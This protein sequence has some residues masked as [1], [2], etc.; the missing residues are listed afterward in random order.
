MSVT[1]TQDTLGRVSQPKNSIW[2]S[3]N[4]GSGKTR[5]LITRVAR[6]LLQ[7][8][9]PE[10]ILC[11]TYTTAAASE[12]QD[13]LF[14]ELGS[15]SM[16]SD[17]DLKEILLA[18]DGNIFKKNKKQSKILSTARRLFAKALETP[19]GL[20]I[21]TI[22]SF[23]GTVLRK[24]PLEINLSPYFTILDERRKR[25]IIEQVITK[26]L[27]E[28]IEIFDSVIQLLKVSDINY[29]IDQILINRTKLDVPFDLDAFCKC[30]N[31]S[32]RSLSSSKELQKIFSVRPDN[33]IALLINSLSN[34]SSAD[35]RQVQYLIKIK[36]CINDTE[37]LNLL[38]QF[39][40]TE[41]GKIRSERSFPSKKAKLLEP[42]LEKVYLELKAGFEIY[43]SRRNE[44]NAI[45][46]AK[47]FYDFSYKFFKIYEKIKSE[48]G[49]LDYD[50]LIIKT[51]D[52]L[53]NYQSKWVLYKLDGGI[54]HILLD[55]AQDTSI[56][57]WEMLAALMED[58]FVDERS[59]S[60]ERTF[61]AVGDEKQ[62]I[63]SFQGA[64][65][66]SFSYMKEFF[67]KKLSVLGNRLESVELLDSFRSSSAIL[68]FVN[69]ILVDSGG[70]GV[71]NINQHRAFHE[72]LPGRVELWPLVSEKRQTNVY[73]WWN[74]KNEIAEVSGIDKLA[75][76]IAIEIKKVLGSDQTLFEPNS[77][78]A[79]K[80]RK[81]SPGDFLILV[82]SRGPLF[83]S[84]LKKLTAHN[85]P[86]AGSDRLLLL[87]ELVIKDLVSLLKF[88][89]NSSDDLSLAEVLRSP[90]LGFSEEDLFKVSYGR[91]ATLYEAL[92]LKFP[93][94]EAVTILN[95]LCER[96]K[97][98]A[99]YELIE[100]VLI[101]HGGRLKMTARL[102]L[103]VNEIL[104][105]FLVQVLNY[106][107][108]EPPS[109]YGFLRW[110]SGIEVAVKRQLHN[111][112]SSIRVMTV[113]GSKGLESPIVIIPDT[114]KNFQK[115]N[116][117]LFLQKDGWL[118]LSD[119][120][121]NLPKEFKKI[122]E[123]YLLDEIEEENR[124]FYVAVTRA[125]NWLIINGV[126]KDKDC[127]KTSSWYSRSKT[128]LKGLESKKK[129]SVKLLEGG[130]L[131]YDYSWTS[132]KTI[133]N[134]SKQDNNDSAILEDTNKFKRTKKVLFEKVRINSRRQKQLTVSEIVNLVTDPKSQ[135]LMKK[136][137][138]SSSIDEATLYGSLVH[139]FLQY[140]PIFMDK[141]SGYLT[142]MIR[143]KFR[144]QLHDIDM[145]SRA[146]NQS[147]SIFEKPELSYLFSNKNILREV[148]VTGLVCLNNKN[149]NS[150]KEEWI[151]GRIDLL[152]IT[153]T[154][155]HIVDFKTN[156]KVPE[157]V[158][159]VS[160]L[161]LS[162][163]ELYT[164]ILEQAY[165]GRQVSSAILWTQKV[166]LMKIPRDKSQN[167]LNSIYINQ[168]LDE[169]LAQF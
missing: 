115:N 122:K 74:F 6:I 14:K 11:L 58:F 10:K 165:P 71:K 102:G 140:L 132:G 126:D 70:T 91:T 55:E 28:N 52:L 45:G 36:Y 99:P 141:S 47:V 34:G 100:T 153:E 16:K 106:E 25:V 101:N 149:N 156:F 131:V 49:V 146:Y 1:E 2:V 12:M 42:S 118:C 163:L 17:V 43:L 8:A 160:P 105:E 88:L 39:F 15:W 30:F 167:A 59:L 107:E 84:I 130:K 29:F 35:I 92:I 87:D 166:E 164:L 82:R 37:K 108:E 67:S 19:G 89:I 134:F 145:V 147:L 13:R 114:S 18:L 46:K 83:H 124:L 158:D 4:A 104:D 31:L 143:Y 75:E 144:N 116:R 123:Q 69:E 121:N 125:K 112:S 162:Q 56:Y 168:V 151:K 142:N 133:K 76:N 80:E 138:W 54:D 136:S 65:I 94:H 113:H 129:L 128:A 21:Q 72:L 20:K 27:N 154:E 148:T 53:L 111:N 169:E 98:L 127:L 51:R 96:E 119:K 79:V 137:P 60:G 73:S 61:Y 66:N 78:H 22:H 44:V 41:D 139:T 117:K 24:F 63:Y 97:Y 23:C 57:Q 135:K 62:S 68:D 152:N 103:G 109:T 150:V 95:D 9:S 157:S 81:V 48:E 5:N 93:E 159:F 86:V 90:I 3:A 64:D 33:K 110:L 40:C 50:D 155:I 38:E 7:G 26:L 120:I 32:C 161:I 77:G 85:L